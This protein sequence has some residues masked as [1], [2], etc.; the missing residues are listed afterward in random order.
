ML[1]DLGG[2]A[3]AP[4]AEQGHAN[5]LPDPLITPTVSVTMPRRRLRER[6]SRGAKGTLWAGLISLA[7]AWLSE[8]FDG[9]TPYSSGGRTRGP[10]NRCVPSVVAI[11]IP[12]KTVMLVRAFPAIG[13]TIG[14]RKCHAGQIRDGEIGSPYS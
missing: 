11:H 4:V 14:P 5:I 3:M 10:A 7:L 6:R 1:D 13:E 8:R 12:A 9:G 2:E